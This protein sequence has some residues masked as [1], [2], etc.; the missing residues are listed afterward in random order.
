MVSVRQGIITQP[1]HAYGVVGAGGAS[2]RTLSVPYAARLMRWCVARGQAVVRG[3]P[4][5][6]VVADPAAVLA[7]QQARSALEVA[8]RE[9]VRTRA[10]YDG[11][12]ATASQLD[13]ASKVLDDARQAD[14]AQ[15]QLGLQPGSMTVSAPFNGVVLQMSAAQGDALQPGAP[16]VQLSRGDA[17]ADTTDGTRHT[18]NAGAAHMAG[19][20][21][22]AGAANNAGH[23]N[24]ADNA[25]KTGD[26]DSTGNLELSVEP[27]DIGSLHA[28]D[29]VTVRAL[30]AQGDGYPAQGHLLSVGAAIDSQTQQVTVTASVVTTG[31]GLLPGSHVA[32]DILPSGTLHWIVPR[33]A[34]LTDDNGAF[35]FQV[36]SQQK[37]H[38]VTVVVRVEHDASYGVDGPLKEAWPV[39]STGNYELEDGGLVRAQPETRQ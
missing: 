1:I 28:G 16:I 18:R 38:R 36:D 34:V 26:A 22:N 24:N 33:S 14:A 32:A 23:A 5:F 7:S 31:T 25:D 8:Q 39:V 37:A 3:T 17:Q 19:N 2:V 21:G 6:D 29:A 35:V 9:L 27:S 15:R 12:L 4:L 11:Q 30:A 20:P 13:A 10:L